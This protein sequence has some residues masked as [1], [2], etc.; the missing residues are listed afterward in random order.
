MLKI[1]NYISLHCNGSA[2][3]FYTRVQKIYIL[4]IIHTHLFKHYFSISDFKSNM[5]SSDSKSTINLTGYDEIVMTKMLSTV[6]PDQT[7][8]L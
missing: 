1:H 2:Y 8:Y 7:I 5:S 3:I 4:E 6:S